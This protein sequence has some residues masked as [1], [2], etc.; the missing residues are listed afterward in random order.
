MKNF[1]I[2]ALIC[3]LGLF[4]TNIEKDI[5][6]NKAKIAKTIQEQDRLT[7]KIQQLGEE[8]ASQSSEL[9]TLIG[10][11]QILEKEIEDNQGRFLEQEEDYKKA[12][13]RDLELQER[14]KNIQNEITRLITQEL[15]FRVIAN[16]KQVNSPDDLVLEELFDT[17][18]KDAKT[19]I[20]SLA[21][22]KNQVK[23]EIAKLATQ[24]KSLQT[25]IKKQNDK[26]DKLSAGIKKRNAIIE[27]MEKDIT[28]Y[29]QRLGKIAQERKNLDEILDVL[30]IKKKQQEQI[31]KADEESKPKH[32]NLN[33]PLEVRQMGSSYRQ[34]SATKYRGKKTIAP[35]DS[36]KVDQKFGTYFDPV[37]KIK[38]FNESVILASKQQNAKVKSVLDGKIV[39]AKD[40]PMLKKV[41]IIE[42]ANQMHTIYAYLDKIAPT[43]RPGL[44]VKR[45]EV[46]GRVRDK[47]SFEVTQKDKHID[48]LEV[49]R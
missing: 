49:I 18:S 5:K 14:D 17:L 41:I 48:P 26:R 3:V 16:Q 11:I 7:K 43:I 8:I 27:K 35:L 9:E 36:Y 6:K 22:E 40:T 39:F 21:E 1:F 46:I 12:Q 4:G 45:G 28:V 33:A 10:Q 32:K 34:V 13:A 15:A 24:I 38:V 31:A 44:R 30:N 25:V 19:R 20:I 2:L 29:N 37:Y 23:R 47:L 42:H